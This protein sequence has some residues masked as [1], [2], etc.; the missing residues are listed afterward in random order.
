[1]R[2]SDF[3]PL[4]DILEEVGRQ[5]VDWR[6]DNTARFLHC[7]LDFKTEADRRASE[8]ICNK[9]ARFYPGVDI[10]SEEIKICDSERPNVYWIIDPI[11]GTASWYNGFDGFVTQAAYI[12]N[13]VPMFGIVHAPLKGKTWSA[14]RGSGAYMNNKLLPALKSGSR[15]IITD[16]TPEPHGISRKLMSWMPGTGYIESGSIG[17]KSVMVADGTADFFVKDVC[18]RDWDIAPAAVILH[19]VGGCLSMPDGS[20]YVFSGKFEKLQGF[21]VARDASLMKNAIKLF[22]NAN[23]KR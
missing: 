12:E 14:L 19:E 5:I 4:T 2:K 10:I 16:N 15:C 21:I 7:E 18:V 1:V 3:S 13:G 17:L 9:L 6:L 8:Q 22:S 11:D 20:P 23:S